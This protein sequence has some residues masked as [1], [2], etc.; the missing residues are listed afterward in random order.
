MGSHIIKSVLVNLKIT[1]NKV[2]S[3]K[4]HKEIGDYIIYNEG[5]KTYTIEGWTPMQWM[6]KKHKKLILFFGAVVLIMATLLDFKYEGLFYQLLPN[7]IQIFLSN[8]L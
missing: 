3:F 1:R 7:S 6:F 8:L 5:K 2:N 4:T